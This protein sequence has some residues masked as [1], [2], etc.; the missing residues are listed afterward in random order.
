MTDSLTNIFYNYRQWLTIFALGV[1]VIS[2]FLLRAGHIHI[3][4]NGHNLNEAPIH[5]DARQ[6][7]KYGYNLV[8]NNLYSMDFPSSNPKP[9][10]YRSPGYPMLIALS[11]RLSSGLNFIPVMLYLQAML[12]TL[13]VILTFLLAKHFTSN[14]FSLVAALMVGS[15]PHLVTMSGYLLTETLTCFL[16]IAA[17]LSYTLA[18]ERGSLSLFALAGLLFGWGYMTN[19]T[20]LFLP[21]VLGCITALKPLKSPVIDRKYL[22]AVALFLSV[23]CI[24]P[25][26]WIIRSHLTVPKD[27]LTGYNRAVQTLSHGAYPGFVHETIEKKYYPYLE[28]PLQPQFGSSIGNFAKILWQRARQRPFRYLSWYILEKPFYFW[29]WDILQGQGDVFVYPVKTSIYHEIPIANVKK[30]VMKN[31]HSII[32][33]LSLVGIPVLFMRHLFCDRVSALREFP[34]ALYGT[35]LYFTILFA[36]FAPWP[37]YSIMLRPELY[38]C[39]VWSFE[40]YLKFIKKNRAFR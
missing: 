23:F 20:L 3:I 12:G 31:L 30:A 24:F 4:L 5:G 40:I 29:N 36:V 38:I 33:L 17:L 21:F 34:V 11:M 8:Y 37:R 18:S 32:L 2:A 15:S 6:Y 9:D 7:I 10:A 39:A 14:T 16:V 1:I 25:S 28:D 26:A 13:T 19:E 27:A 35:C 22:E